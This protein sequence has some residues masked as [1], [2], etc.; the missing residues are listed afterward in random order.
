MHVP[1][2]FMACRSKLNVGIRKRKS[3]NA[4]AS[5]LG[6][7]RGLPSSKRFGTRSENDARTNFTRFAAPTA[8]RGLPGPYRGVVCGGGLRF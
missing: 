7:G 2:P 1:V 3:E 5:R 4:R 8:A 6:R